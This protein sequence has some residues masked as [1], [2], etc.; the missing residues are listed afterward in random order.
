LSVDEEFN[1]IGWNDSF[2][3]KAIPEE[4]MR[5][6]L[7][8]IVGVIMSG[9]P[10]NVLEIGSGTGLIYYQLAGKINKYIG[11]D[12]SR[13]SMNQIT[14]RI[15]KGLRNYGT[16][17]LHVCAAHEVALKDDQAVDTII[18][19]SIVQYFPGEDYMT[20]VIGKSIS[21]LKNKGRIIIGDVRDNR[22]LELFKGRLHLKKMHSSSSVKE[23]K[24]TVDQD[25][26][27]EEEL[28]FS[29]DYFFR[30]QS[31]FPEITHIEI[32]WKQASYINE[33]SLYRYTVIIHVGTEAEIINPKWQSWDEITDIDTIVGQLENGSSVIALKDVPNPRLVQERL[34]NRALE[35]KTV[36]TVG[37]I[38]EFLGM[39]DKEAL[40]INKLLSFAKSKGYNY[41]LLLDEDPLKINVLIEQKLSD[42]YIKQPYSEKSFVNN[43]LST[44]IPLF[45]DISSLLQKDIRSLLKQRLPEYMVPSE[46]IALLQFPLTRNGKVD[47]IFL[48]ERED[49]GF[50]NVLNYQPA[51][52]KVEHR[53]VNIWQELLGLE[54]IGI[55]DNFFELGGH[56]LLAIRLMSAIKKELD[57]E[58]AVNDIFI[59]PT[60]NGLAA[61]LEG[62]SKEQVQQ[63]PLTGVKYLVP[64]KPKGNKTPLYIICGGGGT[65][66]PFR[67]F[68]EMFD[69]DQPVYAL[70]PPVHITESNDFPDNIEQIA[71]LY[72]DEILMQNP[73]GPYALSGHCLGGFVAF[74]MAQQMEKRGKKIE[75]LAMFDA[76]APRKHKREPGTFKNLFHIRSL[77]K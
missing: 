71:S 70:Q 51:V 60:I 38:I 40:E 63:Q 21:F 74:E 58:L 76:F 3:G 66:T 4:Q 72:I 59:H 54:R 50:V 17:E 34:L 49:R 27:K 31:H 52:T 61:R 25:V 20:D 30:L 75:L 43:T 23:F 41:H 32:K 55:H 46:M 9:K 42:G 12:F 26:L 22:L 56:S 13:S 18:L 73:N 11:T 5:E 29:P 53:L 47:R 68:A 33:L 35:N 15:S 8:D 77:F 48:S 69:D 10:Q 45:T 14:Q 62:Q 65:A 7:E 37:D 67:E 2:T 64:L 6:W 28:C 19:N 24:W 39:D 36:N 57:I 44:N 16:T 1:I